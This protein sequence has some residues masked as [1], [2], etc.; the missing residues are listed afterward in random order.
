MQGAPPGEAVIATRQSVV[1]AT[2]ARPPSVKVALVELPT[3]DRQVQPATG[4]GL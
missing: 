1:T 3:A 2:V 4:V